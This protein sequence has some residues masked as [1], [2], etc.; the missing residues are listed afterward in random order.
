MK[1]RKR[2]SGFVKGLFKGIGKWRFFERMR[3]RERLPV[4]GPNAV[5]LDWARRSELT[6]SVLYRSGLGERDLRIA[7]CPINP[8]KALIRAKKDIRALWGAYPELGA[9]PFLDTLSDFEFNRRFFPEYREHVIHQLRVFLTGLYLFDLCGPLRSRILQDIG[10]ASDKEG[11][12]EFVRRWTACSIFHDI[13]YVLENEAGK[14][15]DGDAWIETKTVANACLAAPMS[16]VLGDEKLPEH[17]ERK[18]VRDE[19]IYR[20]Q[21]DLHR[22]LEYDKRSDML[23]RIAESG[24][25]AG[26]GSCEVPGKTPLRSYYDYARSHEPLGGKRPGFRDH[27][28]ESALLLLRFWFDFRQYAERLAQLQG[29]SL[30]ADAWNDLQTVLERLPECEQSILAAAGAMAL[31]N[32]D[33]NLWNCGDALEEGLSLHSFRIRL[34]TPGM[35][36]AFLL[37][38]ADALQDWD[39][40]RFRAV[41][42]SDTPILDQRDMAF[43]VVGDNIRLFFEADDETYKDPAATS[44]SRFCR[45]KKDM[46]VRL[47]DQVVDDL[48]RWGA[49]DDRHGFPES[50]ERVPG[51]G[52]KREAG[53][54]AE[55][56][57]TKKIEA[58]PAAQGPLFEST[59]PAEAPRTE[60]PGSTSSAAGVSSRIEKIR[61]LYL[62]AEIRKACVDFHRLCEE[63]GSFLQDQAASVLSRYNAHEKRVVSGLYPSASEEGRMERQIADSLRILLDRFREEHGL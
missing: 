1:S 8:E 53:I 58:S 4:F 18:I 12:G 29:H 49:C 44:E 33:P 46:K 62:D 43:C 23:D 9:Y 5:M 52:K 15:P 16:F 40:P 32:I 26:L 27:G 50:T 17:V 51:A 55:P 42:E 48:I 7:L 34:S 2:L 36:L 63:T 11:E 56:V 57:E 31:H 13:G 21:I 47:E 41:R 37:C 14:G 35:A 39:R 20:L 3:D 25:L 22:H 30:L 24:K 10:L 61:T 45:M 38:L 6:R 60:D 54:A 59:Q 28:I 19:Q